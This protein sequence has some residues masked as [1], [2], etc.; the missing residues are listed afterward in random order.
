[1]SYDFDELDEVIVDR[2]VEALEELADDGW[3][4]QVLDAANVP[5]SEV[6]VNRVF[7]FIRDAAKA[8]EEL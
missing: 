3:V 5:Y 4:M 7:D 6:A 2:V 1:M 8:I